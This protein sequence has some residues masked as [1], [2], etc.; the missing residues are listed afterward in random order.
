MAM[1]EPQHSGGL[2][3]ALEAARRR[4]P[5]A[6]ELVVLPADLPLALPQEIRQ[7]AEAAATDPVLVLVPSADGGTNALAL[8]PPGLIPFR[9][10]PD[11]A[12]RHEDE[13]R[14]LGVR[15]LRLSLPSLGLDVDTPADLDL[16]ATL[17][18]RCR[19]RTAAA[20]DLLRPATAGSP[21]RG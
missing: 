7:L 6:R 11:S 19:P 21:E 13:A 10:G 17:R 1:E 4:F 16:V 2:N 15:P 8:S 14:R 9:F 3:A 20:L 18:E 5:E 12:R